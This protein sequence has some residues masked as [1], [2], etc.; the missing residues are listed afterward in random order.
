MAK[1]S[2]KKSFEDGFA[3]GEELAAV[4]PSKRLITARRMLLP[5]P[6]GLVDILPQPPDADDEEQPAGEEKHHHQHEKGYRDRPGMRGGSHQHA[7]EARGGRAH[8]DA[9][10]PSTSCG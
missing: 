8:R 6:D 7:H 2:S 1:G 3:A 9:R 5:L 10:P 4:E